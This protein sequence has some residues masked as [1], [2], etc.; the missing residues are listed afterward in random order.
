MKNLY[1]FP[2]TKQM[3]VLFVITSF[4]VSILWNTNIKGQNSDKNKIE[5]SGKTINNVSTWKSN[6]RLQKQSPI[7]NINSQSSIIPKTGSTSKE[8]KKLIHENILLHKL[9]P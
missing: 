4:I 7:A 8:E 9:L 3:P 5:Q 2:V 1:F 6:V